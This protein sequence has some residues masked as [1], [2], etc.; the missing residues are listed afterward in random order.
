MSAPALRTPKPTPCQAC[1]GADI[2]FSLAETT[3]LCVPCDII[4]TAGRVPRPAPGVREIYS[5][6]RGL[7]ATLGVAAT[8]VSHGRRGRAA[9]NLGHGPD[10]L[11]RLLYDLEQS[12]IEVVA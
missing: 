2:V 8:D 7:S 4:I 3:W 11:D 1:G 5:R 10:A 9:E 12:G 6:L